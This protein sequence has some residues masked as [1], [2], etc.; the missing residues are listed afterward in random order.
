MNKTNRQ[1]FL[2]NMGL[3]SI[4]PNALEIIKARGIYLYTDNGDVY[5][6]LVSGVSVS[7]VG[8]LNPKV[9]KALKKQAGEYMH[10]MV[11]GKYIQSPQV[12]FAKLLTDNLPDKLNSVFY[13]NSGSEAIEGALGV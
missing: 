4:D 6:D 10:L 7:N 13:V 3:P 2:E 1:I 11:Y 5:I 12:K 9:V 8:H